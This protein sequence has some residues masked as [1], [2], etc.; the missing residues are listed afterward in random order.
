MNKEEINIEIKTIATYKDRIIYVDELLQHLSDENQK[1]IE[2]IDKSIEYIEN[3]IVDK[4]DN[5]GEDL[6]IDH[7]LE[8]LKGN[9]KE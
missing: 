8:I 2:V 7:L 1:Y 5:T 9:D 4:D 3:N 6:E